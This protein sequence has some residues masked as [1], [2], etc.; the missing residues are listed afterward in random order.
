MKAD[1]F[2]HAGRLAFCREVMVSS[3]PR[4]EPGVIYIQLGLCGS[5]P[6]QTGCCLSPPVCLSPHHQFKCWEIST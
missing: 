4:G 5:Q 3:A 1:T 6:D 2:R